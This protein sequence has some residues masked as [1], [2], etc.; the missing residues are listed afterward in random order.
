MI[1]F[2]FLSNFKFEYY[3][4]KTD[5]KVKNEEEIS[6]KE[7]NRKKDLIICKACKNII[8][9]PENKIQINGQ[10]SH[11]FQNPA[12]AIFNIGCF[13]VTQGCLDVSEKTAEFSWFPGFNWVIVVCSNCYTHMGW[14]YSMNGSGFYGLILDKIVEN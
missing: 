9:E 2:D 10:F 7:K 11:T 13:S 4:V 1:F 14:H 6:N 3:F 12:G 5:I 8:T